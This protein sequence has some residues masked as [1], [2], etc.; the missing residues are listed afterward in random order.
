MYHFNII[1]K[2]KTWY[3]IS[4][5]LIV[6]SLASLLIFGLNLGIDFTGGSM[7]DI[8]FNE[9]IRPTIN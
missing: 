5:A 8:E 1:E 6:L 9:I 4:S 7:L 3:T 2:T